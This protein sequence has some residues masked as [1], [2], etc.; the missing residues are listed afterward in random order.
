MTQTAKD[1]AEGELTVDITKD[2]I[3]NIVV[4][5]AHWYGAY[6]ITFIATDAEYASAKTSANF[7]V[8]PIN[9]PPIVQKAPDQTINEKEQFE[10][11]NLSDLVSDVDDDVSKIKWTV[12]GGKDL[13][14]II[15]KYNVAEVT[16]PNENWNGPTETFTFTATDPHGASASFKTAFTVK[17]VNDAP[18]FV[19]QIPDQTIAEKKKFNPIE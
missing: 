1:Q 7:T 8:R 9:D 3:A 11:I 2:R 15:D 5:D 4:P 12:S 17:S 19:D 16:I 13:K 6:K 10:A 18:E 14:V